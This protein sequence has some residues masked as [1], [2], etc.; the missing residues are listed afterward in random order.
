VDNLNEF[1]AVYLQVHLS[2]NISR[3]CSK[4]TRI[5]P[6]DDVGE[7]IGQAEDDTDRIWAIAKFSCYWRDE[8]IDS[9]LQRI[10]NSKETI[11]WDLIE[12]LSKAGN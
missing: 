5:F 2:E 12:L 6:L 10:L 3:I 9:M 1:N 7:M 8:E 4:A 11:T